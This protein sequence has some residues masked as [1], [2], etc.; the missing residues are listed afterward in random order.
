MAMNLLLKF[1]SWGF[2]RPWGR[3]L[4]LCG[5]LWFFGQSGWACQVEVYPYLYYLNS[6]QEFNQ[7]IFPQHDC[8]VAITHKLLSLIQQQAGTIKAKHLQAALPSKLSEDEKETI[9]IIPAEISITSLAQVILEQGPFKDVHVISHLNSTASKKWCGSYRPIEIDF[10][11]LFSDGSVSLGEKN[12]KLTYYP[13]TTSSPQTLWMQGKVQEQQKILAAQSSIAAGQKLDPT[14]FRPVEIP[15]D[16]PAHY[17]SEAS[18][19]IYFKA[20]K[21]LAKDALLKQQD[22]TAEILVRPLL[23]VTA[24]I[25]QGQVTMKN[26]AIARGTGRWGDTISVEVGHAKKVVAGKVIGPNKVLIQI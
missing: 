17:V 18:H 25:Q 24:I 22:L 1:I 12:F 11:S 6:P 15:V 19:L 10:T 16:H 7:G 5:S 14:M 20:N 9:S 13:T 23:P 21:A 3:G 26:N 8:P 2:T 4:V